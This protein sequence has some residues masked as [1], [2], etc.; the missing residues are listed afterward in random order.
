MKINYP[1]LIA[2]ILI[3]EFMGIIGSAFTFPSI[4][5]WYAT[6]VK[7]SFSPP[8]WIFGPVWTALY[9]LMGVSLYLVWTKGLKNKNVKIAMKIFGIQL[10]LNSLW[11]I[12]FFGLESPLYALIEII[13]LWIVVAATIFKF[14]KISK[15]AAHLLIPYL[16][17]VSF[18]MFL[19][20]NI[21]I[22]N[23]V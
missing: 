16:L 18:A 10:I 4:T 11:P 3:S 1:K 21:F 7:P 13:F 12:L 22:L 15:N 14:Y 2:A 8:K 19:N 20:Y 23:P 9:F 17:W 5:T 6:L